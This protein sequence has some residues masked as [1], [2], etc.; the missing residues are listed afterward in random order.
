V[1]F[2][3]PSWVA[4]VIYMGLHVGKRGASYGRE[5]VHL[6]LYCGLE[7]ASPL[8]ESS[9]GGSQTVVEPAFVTWEER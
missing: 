1:S 6:V 7:G 8:W 3:G 9:L 4:A 2:L 5:H